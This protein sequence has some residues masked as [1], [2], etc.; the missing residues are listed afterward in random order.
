MKTNPDVFI[1]YAHEDNEI[2]QKLEDALQHRQVW[3]D[4]R[5]PNGVYWRPEI[6]INLANCSIVIVIIS[7][8]SMDSAYVTYEWCYAWLHMKKHLSKEIYW[9]YWDK[10]SL[11]EGMFRRL[12]DFNLPLN[13][14][15]KNSDTQTE[16]FKAIVDEIENRL[17]EFDLVVEMGDLLL[18]S[19]QEREN[20]RL[21]GELRKHQIE[22]ADK[23][24]D[25]VYHKSKA[26]DYLHKGIKL[27]MNGDPDGVVMK[28]IAC[29]LSKV[30]DQSSVPYLW[31][32]YNSPQVIEYQ[33]A[34]QAI[35]DVLTHLSACLY[36]CD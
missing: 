19:G 27:L 7:P 20:L 31:L 1:S 34:R 22:V 11:D 4:V 23:L 36:D 8:H 32:A 3:R 6:D 13:K 16:D 29:A 26:R 15:L 21:S 28:I 9:V 33:E 30:G 25:I 35:S 5:I 10:L 18:V 2:A 14:C 12:L 17:E 24:G